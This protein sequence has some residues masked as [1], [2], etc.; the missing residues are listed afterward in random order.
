MKVKFTTLAIAPYPNSAY[1]QNIDGYI[2]VVRFKT[3][4][5][6]QIE[7]PYCSVM[8][9]TTEAEQPFTG[10][11][12][13]KSENGQLIPEFKAKNYITLTDGSELYEV[14]GNGTWE[15]IAVY[16][17]DLKRFIRE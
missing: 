8:G 14:T 15:L 6:S 1:N 2:G 17:A 13:I 7:I 16:N 4:D 3:P 5:V 11:G 12:F 10:N 9:G